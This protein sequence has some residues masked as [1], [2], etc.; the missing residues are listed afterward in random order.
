MA[1]WTK[2][3]VSQIKKKKNVFY[4]GPKAIGSKS[5]GDVSM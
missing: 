2:K 5:A 1:D 4:L 3:H